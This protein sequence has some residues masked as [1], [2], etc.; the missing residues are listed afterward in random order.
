MYE[1]NFLWDVVTYEYIYII[2]TR[3]IIFE[4]KFSNGNIKHYKIYAG[5]NAVNNDNRF[6]SFCP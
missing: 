6:D 2:T 3:L 4:K 5:L 1:H